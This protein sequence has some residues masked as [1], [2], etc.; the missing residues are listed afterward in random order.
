MQRVSGQCRHTKDGVET[1]QIQLLYNDLLHA[2][3]ENG[4][5]IE[6]QAETVTGAHAK[7]KADGQPAVKALG[8]N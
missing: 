5:N 2:F 6:L 7:E 1:E 8:D 4:K 3:E